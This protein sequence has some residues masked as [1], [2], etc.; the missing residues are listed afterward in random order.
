M[1]IVA[2]KFLMANQL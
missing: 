1:I 2:C